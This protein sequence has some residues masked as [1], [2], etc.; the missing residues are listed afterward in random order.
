MN[1]TSSSEE[2]KE[3]PIMNS[4]VLEEGDALLR[5]VFAG[6]VL[7]KRVIVVCLSRFTGVLDEYLISRSVSEDFSR[8]CSNR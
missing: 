8:F 6:G 5:E 4:E 1:I 7:R 2:T 3:S